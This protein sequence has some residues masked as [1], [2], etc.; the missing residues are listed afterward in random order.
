VRNKTK[1][2]ETN[3]A[4]NKLTIIQSPSMSPNHLIR[5][6]QNTKSMTEIISPVRLL[7]QI[8]DQDFSNPSVTDL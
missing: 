5:F 1:S 7:S 2:L 6:T 3:I 8:A 4:V